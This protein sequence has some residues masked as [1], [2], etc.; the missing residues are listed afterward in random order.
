MSVPGWYPNP[1]GTATSRYW[2]G[3][4]WTQHTGPPGPPAPPTGYLY[5]A[6]MPGAMPMM[7]AVETNGI[8]TASL[9]LGILGAVIEWGGILTLAAG[10]L[11]IVF[12]VIGIGKAGRLGNRGRGQAIAGLLLGC[13]ALVAYFLWGLLTVGIL[14]II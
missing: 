2:D 8:A 12:G 7:P 11:A 10:V 6:Q 9:V 3:N 5:A 14:W 13:I 4:G 1:D